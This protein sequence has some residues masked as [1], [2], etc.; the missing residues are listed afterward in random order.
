MTRVKELQSVRYRRV[1]NNK[2]PN[3]L[4]IAIGGT[5]NFLTE[6]RNVFKT[7]EDAEDLLVADPS[8]ISVLS[9]DL[10]TSCVVGASVSLPPGQTPA[11]L[12][13]PFD[14]ER[15]KKKRRTRRAKRKPGSRKRRR[16]RKKACKQVKQPNASRYFDLVVKCKA[17]S[18]PTHSFPKWLEDRKENATGQ[19]TGRTIQDIETALPPLKGEGASFCKYIAARRASEDDL[20][21]FYNNTN[22]W[23]HKWDA[24]VCRKEEFYKVAEGLLNMIGGS[25]GRPKEPHQHVVIAIGL[26]K[27]TAAHGPPSLDGTLVRWATWSSGSANTIPRNHAQTRTLYCKTCKRLRQRDVMASDNMNAAVRNHLVDQQRPLYLQPKRQNGTYAWTGVMAGIGDEVVGAFQRWRQ[28][29]GLQFKDLPKSPRVNDQY[30]NT[31][32]PSVPPVALPLNWS[33]P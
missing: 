32:T 27:F 30:R 29:P 19:S 18:Q 13:Q 17:V 10:G 20:D 12:K 26:A 14:K 28:R 16:E 3:P 15:G 21:N 25:V 9:L 31:R 1:S 8:Q 22:Y 11:T 24:N 7:T 2:M 5:N 23:K 6:A 4:S 33:L